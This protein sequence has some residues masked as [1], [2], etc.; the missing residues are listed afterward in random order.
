MGA[1]SSSPRAGVSVIDFPPMKV[2]SVGIRGGGPTGEPPLELARKVIEARLALGDLV[3]S[4]E[5]RSLGYNSPMVAPNQR[6]WEL[7]VAL[8]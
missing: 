6:F 1:P 4:G 2:L 7:Q 5:W 3:S 8:I